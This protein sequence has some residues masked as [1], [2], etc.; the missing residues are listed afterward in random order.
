[1]EPHIS[2]GDDV[3]LAQALEPDMP[4]PVGGVVQFLVPHATPGE[5]ETTWLHRI[6][7]ANADG[8][9]VTSGD[10]NPQVDSA[11]L[12]REQITG[13]GRLLV[14]LIGLPGLWLGTGR[15][16]LLALW[17]G[18]TFLAA[19]AVMAVLVVI[20]ASVLSAASFTATTANRANSFTVATQWADP[21]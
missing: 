2:A 5:E 18:L 7:A 14:P 20:S 16:S 15:L 6:V 1:M 17:A 9:F 4:A 12:T 3:V 8:T 10:A 11:P 19:I 21:P 13:Q